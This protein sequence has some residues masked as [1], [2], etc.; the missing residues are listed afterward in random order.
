MDR[1]DMDVRTS[2]LRNGL[3]VITSSLPHVESVTLGIWVGVGARCE[4][5]K[6]AGMSH[7]IEHLLFKGTAGRTA[8]DISQAIEGRGGYLNAFTQEEN[9]CY[10]AQ[11]AHD[12]AW[13][14]L[15]VLSDMYRHSRLDPK[16]IDKERGVII[17][18]IM[19]YRDQPQHAVHD[20][21]TE[22]LWKGHPLGRPIAGNERAL[23]SMTRGQVVEFLRKKYV[24]ARTLVAAAGKVDHDS[25]V[26][27]V[28]DLMGSCRR[29]KGGGFRRVVASTAQDQLVT[30]KRDIEQTH[31]AAG[32]RLFGRRDGRRYAL[33][34]LSAVLGE[35]MSSRLFQVVREKH[36]LAYSVNSSC[37]LYSES[38]ALVVS[39]G[40]DRKRYLKALDLVVRELVRLKERPVARKELKLAKDY[41]IGQLRLGLESTSN[42]MLWLG[43][44]IMAHGRFITPDESVSAISNVTAEDIQRLARQ[45]IRKGRTSLAVISPDL[46]AADKVHMRAALKKL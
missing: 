36:G 9:T 15:D 29:G 33:K 22:A 20:M 32:I 21:L 3:R 39:A 30:E 46:S 16:E 17:E 31:L 10:Y 24:P 6:S 7:F 23:R 34:V 28:K 37:H 18:E 38:G 8:K 27:W 13:D 41:V 14:A 45:V 43:D 4:T 40:L 2:R 42:Q 11:V 35:N 19:M 12:H 44:N 5:R 1:M 26:A 25:C